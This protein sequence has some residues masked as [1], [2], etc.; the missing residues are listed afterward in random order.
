MFLIVAIFIHFRSFLRY[1][2]VLYARFVEVLLA[3]HET[4]G[5][6]VHGGT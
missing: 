6:S 4:Q 2:G 1:S 3:G 5:G